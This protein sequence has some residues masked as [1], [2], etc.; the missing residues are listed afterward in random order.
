MILDILFHFKN[1]SKLRFWKEIIKKKSRSDKRLFKKTFPPSLLFLIMFDFWDLFVGFEIDFQIGLRVV[2]IRNLLV[3]F[4]KILWFW[5][6]NLFYI[7]WG[8]VC[9]VLMNILWVFW[10]LKATVVIGKLGFQTLHLG[11]CAMPFIVCSFI[12]FL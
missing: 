6:G 12:G 7:E 4:S 9:W 3:V 2:R 1:G 8:D 5:F 10:P 11:S